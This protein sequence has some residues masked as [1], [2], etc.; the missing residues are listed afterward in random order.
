MIHCQ[1]PPFFYLLFPTSIDMMYVY[2]LM[3]FLF[4]VERDSCN[5]Y[6]SQGRELFHYFKIPLMLSFYSNP[7]TS[8]L[9]SL[10]PLATTN[11]LFSISIILTFLKSTALLSAF[12]CIVFLV[13]ALGSFVFFSLCSSRLL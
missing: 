7:N 4:H 6:Y 8:P 9:S 2:S 11:T 12:L 1:F 5:C 10:Q 13:I 3:S